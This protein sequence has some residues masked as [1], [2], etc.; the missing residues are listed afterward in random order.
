MVSIT[1][2]YPVLAAEKNQTTAWDAGYVRAQNIPITLASNDTIGS[3]GGSCVSF[4][5]ASKKITDSWWS[6]Y[7][8]WTHLAD[9]SYLKVVP[10]PIIGDIIIT[11]EGYVGHMGIITTLEYDQKYAIINYDINT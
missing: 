3:Y 6:P 8:L 10:S 4:V 1:L 2:F 9:F 7:Y 11:N 5:K